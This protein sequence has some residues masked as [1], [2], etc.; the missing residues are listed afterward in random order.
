MISDCMEPENE[1][2]KQIIPTLGGSP[3]GHLAGK[4][5]TNDLGALELPREVGHDVDRIGTADTDGN[6]AETTGVGSV[7]VGTDHHTTGESVVLQHD[8]VDDTRARLP[9]TDA[10]LG[11]GGG[12]KVV[13]LLVDVL[14]AGQVLGAAELGL[15]QVVAVHGRGHGDRGQTGRHELEQGHLGGG[16][17]ASNTVGAQLEVRRAAGNVLVLGVVQVAV[18][19]LL[20]Q[21]ERVAETVAHDLQV[22]LHL[23]VVDVVTLVERRQ[24]HLV[25]GSREA[26]EGA[27]RKRELERANRALA[28]IQQKLHLM[29]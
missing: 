28:D 12:Q 23:L 27:A 17:L 21:R 4:L 8:L 10:V 20:G 25:G 19:D 16:V 9:E 29:P 14:G 26:A 22:V 6:H 2:P 15:D 13:D 1:H 11:R 18:D 5:N 3:A 24:R 7:R